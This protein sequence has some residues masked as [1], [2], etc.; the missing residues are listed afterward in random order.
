MSGSRENTGADMAVPRA[1]ARVVLPVAC[2]PE[3][4]IT[5]TTAMMPRFYRWLI[6]AAAA[7]STMMMA[8]SAM[9]P[10]RKRTLR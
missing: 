7:S 10:L 2:G 6:T 8:T 5:A 3:T 4:T 9:R 1:I